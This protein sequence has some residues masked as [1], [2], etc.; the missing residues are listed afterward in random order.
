[1]KIETADCRAAP[2]QEHG[3]RLAI[4]P[5]LADRTRAG[6]QS[7]LVLK[8]QHLSEPCCHE[9]VG[10]G[11]RLSRLGLRVLYCTKPNSLTL[12]PMATK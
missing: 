9:P 2:R 12:M 6:D 7:N 5:S 8:I 11:L 10:A 1:M 4:S 3:G